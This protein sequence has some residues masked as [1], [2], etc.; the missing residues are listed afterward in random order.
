MIWWIALFVLTLAFVAYL[1]KLA[2]WW[3]VLDDP[4]YFNRKE[5]AE[6]D[7]I[8]GMHRIA[9]GGRINEQATL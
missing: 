3:P 6:R 9:I 7:W 1:L 5:L 4:E 8:S 2:E